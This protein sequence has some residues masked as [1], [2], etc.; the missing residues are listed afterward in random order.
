MR[1]PLSGGDNHTHMSDG[2]FTIGGLLR[3]VKDHGFKV[4]AITD[5][6]TVSIPHRLQRQDMDDIIILTGT[7]LTLPTVHIVML[8]F[9]FEPELGYFVPNLDINRLSL[10]R[11]KFVAHPSYQAITPLEYKT[12]D[13]ILDLDGVELYNSGEVVFKGEIDGN[14]YAGDDLHE[15]WQVE[16]SWMEMETDSFDKETILEKLKVGDYELK[17]NA[18]KRKLYFQKLLTPAHNLATSYVKSSV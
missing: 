3:Y 14:F 15:P 16:T 10:S 18:E 7:E 17:N 11:L 2:F 6:N 13:R 8:E 9:P 1:T 12:L 5:H 4:I